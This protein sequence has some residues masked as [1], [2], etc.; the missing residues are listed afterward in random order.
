MVEMTLSTKT[1]VLLPSR[2]ESTKFPVLVNRIADPVYSWI[3]TNSIMG[4]INQDHFIV[5]ICRILREVMKIKYQRNAQ[6]NM[7][8]LCL[9]DLGRIQ[10]D[11]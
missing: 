4:H 6:A 3:I 8:R 11:S 9:E 5:F 1:S 2:C 10:C 7:N